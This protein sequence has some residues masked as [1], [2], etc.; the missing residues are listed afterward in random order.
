M[1]YCMEFTW[2]RK[3]LNWF[4]RYQYGI[5]DYPYQSGGVGVAWQF[6]RAKP[7]FSPSDAQSMHSINYVLIKI[8]QHP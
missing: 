8:H 2:H 1:I 4:I 6:T 7:V 5:R 3:Y